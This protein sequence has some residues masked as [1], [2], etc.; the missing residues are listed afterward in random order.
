[1]VIGQWVLL[2]YAVFM[3][4][5]GLMGF[6]AGSKVSLYAGFGSGVALL[7]ALGAT[8]YAMGV[9]LWAGCVL[10][11]RLTEEDVE[12]LR[13][14]VTRPGMASSERR[15]LFVATARHY[16]ERLGLGSFQ[17]A[18]VVLRELATKF[19]LIALTLLALIAPVAGF[20]W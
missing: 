8:Y 12:F 7:A 18:R 14:L 20:A 2:A 11:A 3:V 19:R 6:R 13:D 17:D 9:G 15:K 4:L 16:A 10:A 5:G 1:M